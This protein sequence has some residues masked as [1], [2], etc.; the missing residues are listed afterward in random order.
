[1]CVT[2]LSQVQYSAMTVS[3]QGTECASIWVTRVELP[4]HLAG[5]DE[6]R[7]AGGRR[8]NHRGKRVWP[9]CPTAVHRHMLHQAVH[10]ACTSGRLLGLELNERYGIACFDTAETAQVVCRKLE[11]ME[12]EWVR[13]GRSSTGGGAG[14][15]VLDRE[16]RCVVDY[17]PEF[18]PQDQ[19]DTLLQR[20]GCETRWAGVRTAAQAGNKRQPRQV[21]YYADSPEMRYHFNGRCWEPHP[22]TEDLAKLKQQVESVT[23]SVF[24]SVLLNLYEDGQDHVP[25]HSDDEAIYGDLNDC[26]IASVSLGAVRPFQIRQKKDR[27]IP[28]EMSSEHAKGGY[29]RYFLQHGSLLCI[30]IKNSQSKNIG[31]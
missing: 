13:T 23:G 20:L 29:V 25:W 6:Q 12:L 10:A 14:V 7:V 21:C 30:L 2:V 19:A 27:G 11:A 3:N 15:M 16:G 18:L 28:G 9:L 24:N 4:Q 31:K 5:A 26:T 8:N 1:M 22:W 17:R